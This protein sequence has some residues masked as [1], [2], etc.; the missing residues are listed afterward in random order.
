LFEEILSRIARELDSG[1]LPYMVIGGQAVLL[2]GEPRLTKDIDITL[3][4]GIEGLPRVEKVISNLNIRLLVENPDAFVRKTF[5]LPAQDE[6]SG[7]RIDFVFSF[8]DYEKQAIARAASVEM[9][10]VPV[11]FATLEDVVVHKVVAGRPRDLDDIKS[12]VLKNPDYD[13]Q[14][15][16][17]WLQEFDRSLGENYTAV[18]RNL[19]DELN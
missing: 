4:V 19:V 2:Y 3:G 1:G 17:R 16:E 14:Y 7:I 18:F 12:I 5:V 9:R 8:S 10:G 11:K 15:I 6:A 13:G